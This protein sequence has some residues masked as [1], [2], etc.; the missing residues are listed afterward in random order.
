M[1]CPF[2]LFASALAFFLCLC[3]PVW[4]LCLRYV[5]QATDIAQEDLRLPWYLRGVHRGVIY[6]NN[7]F[8]PK[9]DV[10]LLIVLL[11]CFVILPL[12]VGKRCSFANHTMTVLSYHTPPPPS[13][14]YSLTLLLCVHVY[15][16]VVCVCMSMCLC[17]YVCVWVYSILCTQ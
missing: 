14:T 13:H 17:V 6:P 5:A 8:K 15:V 7:L 9:W 11:F 2:G 4:F 3:F 10:F 16:F 12:Q 1:S